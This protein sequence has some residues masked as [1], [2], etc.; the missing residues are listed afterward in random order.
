MK[1]ACAVAIFSTTVLWGAEP[2]PSAAERLGFSFHP[3][4][5]AASTEKTATPEAP[6]AP[7][8]VVLPKFEVKETKIQ[9]TTE[10]V[11]S[12]SGKMALAKREYISPLYSV[13]FGPLSQLAG[14]YLNFLSILGGWHPSEGEAKILYL[15]D[16]RLRK[17]RE[18]DDLIALERLADPKEAAQ[19]ARGRAE[20]FRLPQKAESRFYRSDIQQ[21]D[22]PR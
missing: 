5:A 12:V 17:M 22:Q 16:A 20:L 13:T 11:M 2:A 14:Y 4:D 7:G 9:L 15:Q 6:P 21:H 19:L 8:T 3:P 18:F 1:A 10:D